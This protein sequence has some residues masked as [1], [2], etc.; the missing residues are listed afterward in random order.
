MPTYTI[1]TVQDLHANPPF[2][3]GDHLGG[4]SIYKSSSFILM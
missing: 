2:S 3:L 4:E 1:E